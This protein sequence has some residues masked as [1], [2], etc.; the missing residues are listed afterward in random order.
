MTP[1]DDYEAAHEFSLV[2]REH[3]YYVDTVT[4]GILIKA[5]QKVSLEMEGKKITMTVIFD[6]ETTVE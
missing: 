4:L 2:L 6:N 1:K 5:S 3:G